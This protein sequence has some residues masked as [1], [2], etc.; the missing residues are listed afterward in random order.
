[1]SSVTA[2]AGAPTIAYQIAG[3]HA[4]RSRRRD[5]RRPAPAAARRHP[6]AVGSPASTDAV[7]S[8]RFGVDGVLYKVDLSAAN[9]A[10]LRTAQAMF[11]GAA[12][13]WR[14]RGWSGE[15]L[16]TEGQGRRGR[17]LRIGNDR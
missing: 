13:A 2:A 14:C 5:T 1:M 3:G 15:A 17:T 7:E 12:R 16:R 9:A 6:P 10:R 11:V 8:V 4:P